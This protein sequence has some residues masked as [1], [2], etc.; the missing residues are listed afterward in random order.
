MNIK[1][2]FTNLINKVQL[3]KVAAGAVIGATLMTSGFC[4]AN[5]YNGFQKCQDNAAY[6]QTLAAEKNITLID[7]AKVKNI[8]AKAI[9]VK[10]SNIEFFNIRLH[11]YQGKTS[12]EFKPIYGVA[13][14]SNGITYLLRIDAVSGE[15]IKDK[16][17]KFGKDHQDHH[18]HHRG[19][20]PQ[21]DQQTQ[22]NQ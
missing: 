13:C 4:L 16:F 10:E 21:Q 6:I 15:I 17:E 12:T 9:S 2:Q 19:D 5:E 3:K 18:F 1:E 7:E 14:F 20:R 22:Q 8:T 11:N